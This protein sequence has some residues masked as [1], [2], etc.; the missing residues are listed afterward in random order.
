MDWVGS[1]STG[2]AWEPGKY[3]AEEKS[4]EWILSLVIPDLCCTVLE[5]AERGEVET[6]EKL[7]ATQNSKDI[8]MKSL[9]FQDS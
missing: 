4:Q 5:G 1:S 6:K 8:E 3:R 9:Y 7:I 2:K